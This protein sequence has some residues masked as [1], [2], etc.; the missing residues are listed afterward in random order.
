MVSKYVQYQGTPLKIPQVERKYLDLYVLH[1]VRIWCG[2]I[3]S[4]LNLEFYVFFYFPFSWLNTANYTV[5]LQTNFVCGE[6][7][8]FVYLK[9]IYLFFMLNFENG[10]RMPCVAEYS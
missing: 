2:I 4:Y 9:I 6:A 8:K 5:F 1:K 10:L 3:L 7:A